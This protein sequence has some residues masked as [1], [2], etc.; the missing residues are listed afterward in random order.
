MAFKGLHSGTNVFRFVL[1]L[2]PSFQFVGDSRS[3][4]LLFACDPRWAL[5]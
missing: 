5:R 4:G 1:L 2:C 3:V